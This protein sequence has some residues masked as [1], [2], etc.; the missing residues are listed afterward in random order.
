MKKHFLN[1]SLW[2]FLSLALGV[3]AVGCSEDN[4]YPDVDGQN[5]TMEILNEHIQTAA[6]RT[7]NIKGNLTDNDGIASVTLQCKDLNLNKTI[8]LIEIYGEPKTSYDLDYKFQIQKDEIGESFTIMVTTVDV[9]GR[10]VSR[11]VLVT[12]DG[13][14]ENP[15]FTIAPGVEVT[16]LLKSETKFKLNLKVSDDKALDYVTVNIPSVRGYEPKRIEA[17]GQKEFEYKDNIILPS[18]VNVYEIVLT[19]VDKNGNSTTK[20]STLTVSELQDFEKMYLADVATVEE[21]NSDIFGVPM[22]I[23]H[24]GE[25]EYEAEYYNQKSWYRNILLPQKTD[26]APICFGLDPDDTLN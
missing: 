25:Y 26:F 19:A 12:M 6:G 7:I 20:T 10:S 15:V 4:D 17:N 9:G 3:T 24:T 22:R 14:F 2:T 16:V 13:D 5:P 1:V 18:V 8:D 11:E 23:N 21:L